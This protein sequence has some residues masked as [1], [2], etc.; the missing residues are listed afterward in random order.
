MK[1]LSTTLVFS[2]LCLFLK[3]NCIAQLCFSAPATFTAGSNPQSVASADFNADGFIDLAVAN[4]V[5][6]SLSVLSGNGTG[7]FT[8]SATYTTGINPYVV[9]T[10][11]F[12][13]DGKIDLAVTNSNSSSISV[14]LNLGNV[15]AAATSFPVGSSPRSVVSGDFNG[16]GKADLAVAN[17]NASSLSVLIGNGAGSF[18]AATN[19]NVGSSPTLVVTNDFNGDG[20]ADLAVACWASNYVSVLLGTG[21]GSF[22]TATNFTVGSNPQAVVSADFNGDGFKDLATANQSSANVSVL[23]GT[24][25]GSFGT[26]TNFNVGTTPFSIS[27]ADFNGDSKADLVTANNSASDNISVLLGTGTGS[28]GAVT[29]FADGGQPCFVIANDFNADGKIDL[30]TANN[31]SNNNSVLLNKQLG[32]AG[33]ISGITSLCPATAGVSYTIAPVT[34]AASYTWTVPGGATIVSGQGTTTLSVTYASTSG[35]ITFTPKDICGNNGTAA[36]L[37]VTVN[38]LNLAVNFPTICP[39]GGST[40]LT[41]SA[42]GGATYTW[43]PA[44]G[45][46]ATSGAS[47]TANPSSTSVYTLSAVNTSSCTSSITTTVSVVNSISV[48]VSSISYCKPGSGSLVANGATT[49][50]WTPAAGLS[51]TTGFS[52]MANTTSSTTYTIHGTSGTCTA[53]ATSTVT[54]YIPPVISS[55]IATNPTCFGSCNGTAT[56][57]ATGSLPFTYNWNPFASGGQY[58]SN[59]CPGFYNL[60]LQDIHFCSTTGG[61]SITQPPALVVSANSATVCAGSTTTL[62]ASGATTYT[63]NTGAV[64]T[65]I[66][67]SPTITTTYS[68]TGTN[69]VG[70]TGIG[71]SIVTVTNFNDLSGTIYDTT[72]V[73]GLHPITAGA[74]YLYRQ[75]PGG[76]IAIDTGSLVVATNTLSGT[77]T[78]AKVQPGTYYIKAVASTTTYTG[79]I[80]TYLSSS[81]NAYLWN[82]A[83]ALSHSG[84]ANGNDGGHTITIIETPAQTG[85]GVISGTVTDLGSYGHRL[86]NGGNNV[87]MGTPLKGIDIKLGKNPAGGCTNRTTTGGTGNYIFTNVDTGSYSIYA[88]IP[89]FGMTAILTVTISASNP[90]A[91]N[92]NYCV[93]SVNIYTSCL[94]ATDIKQLAVN[95]KQVLVYP[96]PSSGSFVIE[97][98]DA[99]TC[100][101]YDI[102][103]REVWHQT[104]DGKTT[105]DV[106]SLANGMYNISVLS[107]D[108]ILNKRILITK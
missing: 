21:T 17:T 67:P 37:S 85:T 106:S 32:A 22:G 80:P 25:T 69:T 81:P 93:D 108:S 51:S 99:T 68:V 63:W 16:D 8:L 23:L 88:D 59:L 94:Q 49:Y 72:T 5:S 27:T 101:L 70:C 24:G 12:N 78:F 47:V 95:N 86:A 60:N 77:F 90:Q 71:S 98:A 66:T 3:N 33:T 97:T 44:G 20:K 15:F 34:N 1:K 28:F 65:S 74:V 100:I 89:N 35:N 91:S 104:I 31:N 56:V 46:S 11:D 103:G 39:A 36:T 26:A 45:L 53:M 76:S 75:Q 42:S 57:N 102:N 84:C 30:A 87:V 4:N 107:N 7:T 58:V 62:T 14:L 38:A 2:V 18:G 43:L 96:N 73:S 40:T 92:N 41:A 105:V 10:G 48:T 55:I 64:S 50:T 29:N 52:Q 6:N 82:S 54:V 83:T 9:N 19:F 13:G 79:S 61:F